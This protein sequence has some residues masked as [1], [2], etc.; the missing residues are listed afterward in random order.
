M[1]PTEGKQHKGKNVHLVL[2]YKGNNYKRE[3]YTKWYEKPLSHVLSPK[4]TC[5]MFEMAKLRSHNVRSHMIAIFSSDP[6]SIGK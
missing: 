2:K 6:G 3:K 5:E 4:I 1:H